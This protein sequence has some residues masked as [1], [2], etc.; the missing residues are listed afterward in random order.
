M[1]KSFMVLGALMLAGAVMVGGA[2]AKPACP[3]Q[4]TQEFASTKK[5]CLSTCKSVTDKTQRK[6]CKK[7]CLTD[8]H[9]AKTK[10]KAAKP[11]FPACSPSGAFVD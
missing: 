4:C 3:K 7:Q 8:F 11:T 9:D 1:R 6:A 10:C 5:S 2:L